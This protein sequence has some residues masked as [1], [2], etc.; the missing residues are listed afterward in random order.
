MAGTGF[1]L[2]HQNS[3]YFATAY[4]CLSP[5][6]HN[7][8]RVPE[9]YQSNR[10]L[11]LKKFGSTVLPPGDEDKDHGDFALFSVGP[12]DFGPRDDRNLEPAYLPNSDTTTLL[13][14]NVL[15]TIR[16][17]PAAAPLAGIDYNRHVVTVQVLLCDASYL[18]PAKSRYCHTL[19]LIAECPVSDLN[20]LS[21]SPV[22]A[23]F[24][25]KGEIVYVL[26]G[27]LIRGGG[28]LCQFISIEVI[29][30]GIRKFETSNE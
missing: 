22:F 18:G 13:N 16:G 20:H 1:L 8:L 25:Y 10:V 21:G 11:I 9:G 15:L 27:L 24:P 3:I 5:G 19:Q 30:E 28:R 12:I 4:H 7:R 23:K 29:R 6:D 17:Y 26:V 2:R 14:E